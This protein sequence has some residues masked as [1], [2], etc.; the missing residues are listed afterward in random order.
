[1]RTRGLLAGLG[2][3]SLLAISSWI[4]GYGLSEPE[5]LRSVDP[6]PVEPTGLARYLTLQITPRSQVIDHDERFWLDCTITSI[7]KEP[8]WTGWGTAYSDRDDP[9][10]LT[11]W[12][13]KTPTGRTLEC[14]HG[15]TDFGTVDFVFRGLRVS[16]DLGEMLWGD[17]VQFEP[18]Q[19]RKF[20]V[21]YTK[22]RDGA[23][24]AGPHRVRL[25]YVFDPSALRTT[26]PTAGPFR[27]R[28][29]IVEGTI[30]SNEVVI[31]RK[32]AP[33]EGN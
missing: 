32:S 2:A 15:E 4:L 23:Q 26:A 27:E 24:G 12:S 21:R 31:T 28:R 8:F 14:L 33:K 5:A 17:F 18:G 16:H 13:V 25:R 20:S 29:T 7:A 6:K 30:T 9:G 11:R 1:V 22:R 3:L 10:Q 19:S